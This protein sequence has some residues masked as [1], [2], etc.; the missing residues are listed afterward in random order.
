MDSMGGGGW[1]I[2]MVLGTVVFWGALIWFGVWAVRRFTGRPRGNG[3]RTLEDRF[4][5]GEIDAE[6]FETRRRIL[7]S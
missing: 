3:F 4:A 5:R 2:P 1:M 7:E 6:E